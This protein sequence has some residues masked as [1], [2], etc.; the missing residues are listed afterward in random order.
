[1]EYWNNPLVTVTW[2]SSTDPFDTHNQTHCLFYNAQAKLDNIVTNQRLADLCRWAQ[3]W[4]THDGLDGFVAE[5]QCHYDIANI[6]KLNMWLHDIRRQG[7]VKPWLLQDLGNGTVQAG[8]G[9]SRLKCLERLPHINTVPAFVSVRQDRA[10]AY[11]HLEPVNDFDHFAQLCG[12]E[13]GQEFMFRFTDSAAPYG[14][15][16]YEYNSARTR[17]VTPN[18]DLAIELFV[19]Y[20]RANPGTEITPDWFDREVPWQDYKSSN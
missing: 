13:P 19:N 15:F 10:K 12:A 11:Q 4:L 9:D 17:A 18:Q 20:M 5:P 6:V 7:I 1:M 3:E 2:P 8:T 16:W 14:V